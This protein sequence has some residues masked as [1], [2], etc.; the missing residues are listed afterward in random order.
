MTIKSTQ[1]RARL[2]S[3]PVRKSLPSLEFEAFVPTGKCCDYQDLQAASNKKKYC[4][5]Y[6]KNRRQLPS[7]AEA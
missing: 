7:V 4:T 1:L 3:R 6:R 2:K 5:V